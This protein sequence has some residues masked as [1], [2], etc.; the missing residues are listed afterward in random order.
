MNE[1]RTINQELV[2]SN[3]LVSI[4]VSIECLIIVFAYIAEYLKGARTL[5]YA[6][7]IA[8]A[9]ALLTALIWITFLRKKDSE[10]IKHLVGVGFPLL[11]IFVLFTTENLLTFTYAIPV[12]IIVSAYA[13]AKYSMMESIGVIVVNIIQIIYF[14]NIGVYNDSNTATLE[15]HLIIILLITIYQALSVRRVEQ[16]NRTRE[17]RISAENKKTRDL[18]DKN[19]QIGNSTNATIDVLYR[20]VE[21][22]GESIRSTT[23]AMKEVD[24]GASDTTKNVENQL[25]M[26]S[27]ITGRLEDVST[28]YK[29]IVDSIDKTV[30]AIQDG[31]HNM[32]ELV[33]QSEVMKQNGNAVNQKLDDLSESVKKIESVITIISSIAT[34]TNLLSLNA[35]IEAARAGE[36]GKGFAVVASEIQ[37]MANSTQA[38]TSDI[39]A[40]INEITGAITDVV[41]V[42][43]QMIASL[44]AQELSIKTTAEGFGIIENETS[45]IG[46]NSNELSDTIEKLTVVNSEIVNSISN[47]SA[48]TE[49]VSAHAN[50][51]VMSS[52]KNIE[53]VDDIKEKSRELKELAA[54]LK[55]EM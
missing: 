9:F 40:M 22:L 34:Q 47:I 14:L 10:L 46:V 12:I 53:V 41:S 24:Q 45:N 4:C 28:S 17:D 20:V 43:S 23:G 6:S 49:Q 44:N 29:K 26:T 51:T 27:D 13:D 39:N 42:T 7:G 50:T 18:L 54:Q 30:S 5:A 38:A 15:I 52:E 33:T 35:S 31:K 16:N 11:Y 8:G 21:E 2:G 1:K 37:S 55:Q 19:L 25:E 3:K 32:N 36:A 48:I